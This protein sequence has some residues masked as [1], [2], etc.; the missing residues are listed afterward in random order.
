M[1]TYEY[2]GNI[3]CPS[4]ITFDMFFNIHIQLQRKLQE[5]QLKS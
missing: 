4:S 5:K 1:K 2:F 3:K